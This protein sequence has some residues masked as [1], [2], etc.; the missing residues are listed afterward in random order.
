MPEQLVAAANRRDGAAGGGGGGR[1]LGRRHVVRDRD[2][3]AVLAA[4]HVEQVVRV[5]VELLAD[6]ARGELEAQSAPLAAGPQDGD[7]SPSA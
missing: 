6:R 7:V 5:V 4:A 2:L 1:R 3:V